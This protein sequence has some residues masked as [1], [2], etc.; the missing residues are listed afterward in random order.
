MVQRGLKL[1]FLDQKYLLFSDFFLSQIGRYPTPERHIF[2]AIYAFFYIYYIHYI[3][4]K[5]SLIT[6]CNEKHT[7]SRW[8]KSSQ[9]Y[10]QRSPV[11]WLLTIVGPRLCIQYLC[12]CVFVKGG[13]FR[14]FVDGWSNLPPICGYLVDDNFAIYRR[15]RSKGFKPRWDFP[16]RSID[17]FEAQGA[18]DNAEN[19]C[20]FD[21]DSALDCDYRAYEGWMCAELGDSKSTK[22]SP[23]TGYGCMNQH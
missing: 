13:F 18:D 3:L 9:G 1:T 14:V 16:N 20:V 5:F 22:Y 15:C 4:L 12:I 17:N 8:E 7:I 21:L 10:K 11:R 19:E 23:T 2:F 6:Y